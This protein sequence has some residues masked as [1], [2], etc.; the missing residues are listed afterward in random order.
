MGR[1][2][3]T[4]R[5]SDPHGSRPG[6]E[7]GPRRSVPSGRA[8]WKGRDRPWRLVAGTIATALL[9]HLIF[10]SRGL[11]AQVCFD[12]CV[13]P[14]TG[15]LLL[16][17]GGTLDPEIF[18]RFVELAGGPD[19]RIV[20]IPTAAREDH[21]PPDWEGLQPF[22]KAGAADVRVLHTR[23]RSMADDEAFVEPLRRATGVWFVGGRPWRLVDAYGGTRVL[24]E[25]H[26]LVARGGVI[27][28]TSAGASILASFLI[29]GDP[30]DND[31]LIAP[32]YDD[33]FGFLRGTAVDQHVVVRGRE[34]DLLEVLRR[35]PDLVGI[36]IDEGTAVVVRGDRA[37][38]LGRSRVAFYDPDDPARQPRWLGPGDVFRLREARTV[39]ELGAGFN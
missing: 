20:V 10:P 35:H 4:R 13:G 33:G 26:L 14:P 36:G 24:D 12:P 23:Y 18:Q 11:E 19:A 17:G 5:P 39:E 2:P 34:A 8:S 25:L 27:G 21:F 37:E 38:V 15:A 16:A 29:R 32:G 1:T 30:A 6:R 7:A 9:L 28:G 3:S 31:I 22:R